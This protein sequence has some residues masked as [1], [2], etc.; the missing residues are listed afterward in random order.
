MSTKLSVVS[1]DPKTVRHANK[2]P[3]DG[4]PRYKVGKQKNL[5]YGEA[6][7]A[8]LKEITLEEKDGKRIIKHGGA[9]RLVNLNKMY[10]KVAHEAIMKLIDDKKAKNAAEEAAAE[11]E[12]GNVVDVTSHDSGPEML[13]PETGSTATV[14]DLE[15]LEP[16]AKVSVFPKGKSEAFATV[17]LSKNG[18]RYTVKLTAFDEPFITR[19]LDKVNKCLCSVE[20]DW[21]A[22]N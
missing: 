16:G 17:Q 7:D 18:S 14:L 9:L 15:L 1:I 5:P 20:A 2:L 22:R 6:Y 4:V 19:S 8:I 21:E 13:N 3:C 12:D 11:P 10:V